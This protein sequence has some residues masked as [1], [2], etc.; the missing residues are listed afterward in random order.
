MKWLLAKWLSWF[1]RHP[2]LFSV[3]IQVMPSCWTSSS[4]S[5]PSQCCLGSHGV[6]WWHFYCLLYQRSSLFTLN[7]LSSEITDP[8]LSNEGVS[9]HLQQDGMVKK[10]EKR[11]KVLLIVKI[12]DELVPHKHLQLCSQP[13]CT[14]RIM[15]TV[16]AFYKNPISCHVGQFQLSVVW[17]S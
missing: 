3:V 7:R 11:K 12:W 10:K 15:F 6:S 9:S 1:S 8:D 17:Q 4:F 13:A 2:C 14:D 5:F 16:V